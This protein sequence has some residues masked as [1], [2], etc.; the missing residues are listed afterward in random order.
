MAS[1]T[2]EWVWPCGCGHRLQGSR[3]VALVFLLRGVWEETSGACGGCCRG[4]SEGVGCWDGSGGAGVSGC[5]SSKHVSLCVG[6][7]EDVGGWELTSWSLDV[8]PG[9]AASSL[10]KPP[11]PL[12]S[13]GSLI[14]PRTLSS[15]PGMAGSPAQDLLSL[16][17]WAGSGCPDRMALKGLRRCLVSSIEKHT[18]SLGPKKGSR[19]E[20]KDTE[21]P[22]QATYPHIP[23]ESSVQDPLSWPSSQV[24]P[25]WHLCYFLELSLS[26]APKY[27]ALC[28]MAYV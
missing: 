10:P 17:R 3:L 27:A 9:L 22:T 19:L 2:D 24:S 7:G 25:G 23:H 20:E 13:C 26:P 8:S 5:L 12:S 28:L 21:K 18:R 14:C 15:S 1:S 6:G 16:S 11:H 4:S